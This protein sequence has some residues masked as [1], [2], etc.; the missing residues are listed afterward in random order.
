MVVVYYW[1]VSCELQGVMFMVTNWLIG[2]HVPP[3]Q[4]CIMLTIVD[5][6]N[7][8]MLKRFPR[9]PRPIFSG[10]LHY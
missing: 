8:E 9:L 7:G 3:T 4:K 5:N 2:N 1:S 6:M 10:I